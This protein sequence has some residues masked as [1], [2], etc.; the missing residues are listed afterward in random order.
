[1]S[2]LPLRQR[3]LRAD[4]LVRVRRLVENYHRPNFSAWQAALPQ[5]AWCGA[6]PKET[7][8]STEMS[9]QV[10]RTT[11]NVCCSPTFLNIDFSSIGREKNKKENSLRAPIEGANPKN[12]KLY[13]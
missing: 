7:V 2:A 13:G 9:A 10:A 6:R 12:K 8:R 3:L 4:R 11:V 5:T 1:M